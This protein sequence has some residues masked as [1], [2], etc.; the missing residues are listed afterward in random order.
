MRRAPLRT[1]LFQAAALLGLFGLTVGLHV[2]LHHI[3]QRDLNNEAR[4]VVYLPPA[5]IARVVSLGHATLAADYAWIQA[6]QYYGEEANRQF[7]YRD[8]HRYIELVIDL[9]PRL[10]VAYHLGGT[11]VPYNT[12][13]WQ[14]K[15]V[16]PA[17]RIIQ[18]GL[19][20]WPEDWTMWRQLGFL[21]GIVGDDFAAAAE[22]FQRAAALPGSPPWF[23]ALVTRLFATAGELDRAEAYTMTILEHAED[24]TLAQTMERRA[25]E[26]VIERHLQ[27]LD[28]AVQGYRVMTGE[29]PKTLDELVSFG[30]IVA[31]PEDPL[32]G[33]YRL[34]EDGRAYSTSLQG[35][36]L[37][38]H[39]ELRDNE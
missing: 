31:L 9:D 14:W 25:L 29:A 3:D 27:A 24:P 12:G 17:K 32:G 5:E 10:L 39:D 16:E 35:G 34:G 33:T 37:W 28:S 11:A 23:P 30:L 7:H 19:E 26:L 38:A 15:N 21:Q 13:R 36:R 20:K 2:R 4:D 22:S 1:S 18:R 8:L 6:L